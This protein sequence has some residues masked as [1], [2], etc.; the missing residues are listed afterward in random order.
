MSSMPGGTTDHPQP[1]AAHRDSLH[2][3]GAGTMME[4]QPGH[5][6][7]DAIVAGITEKSS[8]SAWSDTDPAASPRMTSIKNIN[9][10]I[11]STIQRIRRYASLFRSACGAWQ[12]CLL[13]FPSTTVNAIVTIES[14][15]NE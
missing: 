12:H 10:L 9:A 14:S 2:E 5:E 15:S 6:Q 7:A 3:R 13:I 4:R 1:K 8:A 11:P